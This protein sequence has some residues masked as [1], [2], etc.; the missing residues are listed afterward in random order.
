MNKPQ[1]HSNQ[2]EWAGE[3]L[4]IL[5]Q[6]HRFFFNTLY[7]QT[8]ALGEP[9]PIQ[10]LGSSNFLASQILQGTVLL[11]RAGP[12]GVGKVPALRKLVLV[13]QKAIAKKEEITR[14]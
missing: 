8:V 6:S 3:Y 4:N 11:W 10:Q 12:D 5:L 7:V 9:I 1:C 13:A 2:F 14:N